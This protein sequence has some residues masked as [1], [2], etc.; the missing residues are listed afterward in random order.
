MA[1]WLK[2]EGAQ[3]DVVISTRVR[4]ARNIEKL[5]FPHL[6]RGT[7]REHDIYDAVKRAFL[8]DGMDYRLM[9]M[10][11]LP[12]WTKNRLAESHIISPELAS[13]RGGGVIVSPDESISIMLLEEDHFRLQCI[14]SGF[15]PETALAV[16]A[17]LDKMLGKEVAY[18]FSKQFGYLTS[19]PTNVGTGLRISAMV[20]LPALAKAN[21]MPGI[22]NSLSQ[23]GYT[24]RGTYGEG[25]SCKGDVYQ[26]SN[27][28]ML[29]IDENDILT[30]FKSVVGN[31]CEKERTMRR[32]IYE[33]R[34]VVLEDTI[35][36][37]YG[38]LRFSRTM[39]SEEMLFHLSNV[40]MGI[41]LGIIAHI[42]HNTIYNAMMDGMPAMI[43][44]EG[45]TDRDRDIRR[46]DMLREIIK[47]A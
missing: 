26:I 35:M 11:D 37:S 27:R 10:S 17:E 23:I 22:G 39:S 42:S 12:P 45:D 13:Q 28:I 14:V 30:G 16:A 24:V 3:N 43:S 1:E 15:E 25:T 46:A 47:E 4:L 36:R 38:L 34:R 33:S 31:I 29:G 44:A 19:C 21:L 9:K 32:R 2:R 20:H 6:I 8:K 40:N 41:S 18:A 5:P 7:D